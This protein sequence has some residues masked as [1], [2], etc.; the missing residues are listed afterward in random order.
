MEKI[1][2]FVCG[3]DSFNDLLEKCTIGLI[4]FVLLIQ[5]DLTSDVDLLLSQ[6]RELHDIEGVRVYLDL[7]LQRGP[8]CVDNA[9]TEKESAL[10]QKYVGS[11]AD[12]FVTSDTSLQLI[13]FLN[14]IVS[15]LKEVFFE[16]KQPSR[17]YSVFRNKSGLKQRYKTVDGV[18]PIVLGTL[19]KLGVRIVL[20]PAICSTTILEPLQKIVGASAD[21]LFLSTGEAEMLAL[22]Y[23]HYSIDYM[24]E[25]F[26]AYENAGF[27]AIFVP[28]SIIYKPFCWTLGLSA[29]SET[30]GDIVDQ[31]NKGTRF[32]RNDEMGTK[33]ML[34]VIPRP[35]VIFCPGGICPHAKINV[36]KLVQAIERLDL[37]SD[38][39]I[40]ACRE[41]CIKQSCGIHLTG[42][43]GGPNLRS[44]SEESELD[45]KKLR[46]LLSNERNKS[47][48][49]KSAHP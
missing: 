1:F 7:H 8:N 26:H 18:D 40:N 6:I 46:E 19:K 9:L 47:E 48:K 37:S 32:L 14:T 30:I 21:A 25:L 42:T 38:I 10:T 49:E 36:T 33:L 16:Y 4:Q 35:K 39:C 20:K 28:F 27:K 43:I 3:R 22:L 13:V 15:P 12:G 17:I 44:L 41:Q 23:Q 11:E 31:I 24:Y 45:Y 34:D 29:T 5:N 2:C